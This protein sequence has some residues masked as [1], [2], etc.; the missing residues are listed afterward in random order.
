MPDD[1]SEII[2]S[3]NEATSFLKTDLLYRNGLLAAHLVGIEQLLARTTTVAA[4][5]IGSKMAST[6]RST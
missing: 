2:T 3:G 5:P 1:T 6:F 4:L